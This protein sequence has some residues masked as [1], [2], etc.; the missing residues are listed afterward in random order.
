MS[1]VFAF[2]VYL[3]QRNLDIILGI[4]EYIR[5]PFRY[6]RVGDRVRAYL[7]AVFGVV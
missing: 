5:V 3:I 7:V 2:H 1:N 6:A 4:L